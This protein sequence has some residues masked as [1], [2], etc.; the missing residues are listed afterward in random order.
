MEN[1]LSVNEDIP[2]YNY[3]NYSCEDN[4]V[5][6]AAEYITSLGAFGAIFVSIGT[7]LTMTT[8]VLTGITC[9]QVLLQR[10]QIKY[11]K[12]CLLILSIYPIASTC[13]LIA[14]SI[15]RTQL[16][17]QAVTQVALTISMYRLYLL[18]IDIGRRKVTKITTTAMAMAMTTPTTTT[19]PMLLKVGPC[20]C[21]PCLPFPNLQ[22]NDANLSWLRIIVLQFPIVQ[23]I[24][25]IIYLVMFMENPMIY[26][27]TQVFLQPFNI[28]SV[29]FAL[30]GVNVAFMSFKNVNPGTEQFNAIAIVVA[31]GEQKSLKSQE[32]FYKCNNERARDI[33]KEEGS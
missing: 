22:L 17:S 7:I 2:Y 6:S 16:L 33:E 9:Y 1:Y 24:L 18:I 20:C 11:K 8:I 15:P 14:L 31:D 32:C 29:L 28:A 5:P 21:W 23:G 13:S 10:E 27:K 3:I 12:N 4:I 30:Y 19:T 26:A 25:Y